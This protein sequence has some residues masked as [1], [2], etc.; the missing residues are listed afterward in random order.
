[1]LIELIYFIFSF[2]LVS[3]LVYNLISMRQ[4]FDDLIIE[5]QQDI[6]NHLLSMS[7]TNEEEDKK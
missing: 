5:S 4:R 7:K 2:I 1:M 6:K 3:W